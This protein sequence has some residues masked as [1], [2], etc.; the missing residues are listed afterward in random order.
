MGDNFLKQQTEN[1]RKR[2]DLAMKDFEA[3][4]LFPRPDMLETVYKAEPCGDESFEIGVE[5]TEVPRKDLQYLE[6]YIEDLNYKS[7]K[8]EVNI[9]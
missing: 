9:P 6:Q 1:F 3:A 8:E 5:F 2:R 7:M 4:E